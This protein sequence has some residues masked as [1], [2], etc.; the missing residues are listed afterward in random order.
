MTALPAASIPELAFAVTGAERL[1][2]A[3]APTIELV[4]RVDEADGRAI[5]SILLDV[6]I[7]I[8][9]R[10]RAYGPEE[11]VRLFELFGPPSGWGAAL[12]TV[13]WLRTTLVVPPF[14]GAAEV[15]VPVACSYDLEVAASRYFDS[16][17]GGEVPLELLFSGS[18]F[19]T[20][21][22]GALQ[23][24][25]LPWTQEAEFRLPVALWKDTMERYFRGTAWLRLRKD[26]FDRLAAHKARR[27]LGSWEEAVEELLEGCE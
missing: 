18:V 6:Q 3:A 12:R 16:L 20:G 26:T 15:R 13:P 2:H 17:H 11:Q 7:Q 8:A 5:R 21:A 4:L 23:T 9:A 19:Y 22:G 24:A 27:A 10:R 1:E 14:T 25:R